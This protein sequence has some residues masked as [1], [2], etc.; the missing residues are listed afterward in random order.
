MT[1]EFVFNLQTVFSLVLFGIIAKWYVWPALKQKNYYEIMTVLLL[2]SAF[3]FLGSSFAV[4]QATSGLSPEFYGIGA[5]A[6]VILAII[7]V[8]GVFAMR[9]RQSWGTLIAWL[10]AILGTA[11]FASNI[12]KISPLAVADHIGPLMWLM[13]VLGP[14]WMVTLVLI[15]RMLVKPVNK[16]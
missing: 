11:D 12:P 4:P 2:Y 10:Y 3:R 9:Y 8:V 5:K 6:D 1:S 15:W 13:T 16:N 7:C 14:S